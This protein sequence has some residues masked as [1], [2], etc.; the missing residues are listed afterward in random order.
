[1]DLTALIEFTAPGSVKNVQRSLDGTEGDP[2]PGID[3]WGP[4]E[5]QVAMDM[6]VVWSGIPVSGADAHSNI[7][8]FNQARAAANQDTA[9]RRALEARAKN[10]NTGR[11]LKAL[12]RAGD[13]PKGNVPPGQLDALQ[14]LAEIDGEQPL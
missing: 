4:A 10:L 2:W 5:Y 8:A 3:V 13:L 9:E 1:M 6:L 7:A 14:A 12:V 11:V